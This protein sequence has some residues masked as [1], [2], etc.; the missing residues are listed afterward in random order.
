MK[1]TVLIEEGPTSF[2]AYIPD[3]PG[4]VAVADTREEVIALIEEGI[5]YHL[6]EMHAD[7][8]P[9]PNPATTAILVEVES[10][11]AMVVTSAGVAD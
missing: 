1:Y 3:L 8:D 5:G 9:I 10:P 7:G 11:A 2:G 6:E 4:C